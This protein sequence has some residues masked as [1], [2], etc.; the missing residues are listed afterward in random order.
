MGQN[1]FAVVTVLR[2]DPS[3]NLTCV[4]IVAKPQKS[5]QGMRLSLQIY[6]TQ[7]APQNLSLQS[8]KEEVYSSIEIVH[9]VYRSIFDKLVASNKMK[10]EDRDAL[11]ADF[12][13]NDLK[14]FEPAQSQTNGI[15]NT[16]YFIWRSASGEPAA[17]LRA[18]M[19][20]AG[21]QRQLPIEAKGIVV[22]NG[23][24]VELERV[25][26]SPG[27]HAEIVSREMMMVLAQFLEKYFGS[28]DYE[29]YGQTDAGR[30]RLY[31]RDYGFS[32]KELPHESPLMKYL[33]NVP[34]ETLHTRYVGHIEQAFKRAFTPPFD[35][36]GALEYLR[37]F[38]SKRGMENYIPNLV[39]QSAILASQKNYTAALEIVHHLKEIG[40]AEVNLDYGAL[41]ESRTLFDAIKN[42]GDADAALAVIQQHLLTNPLLTTSYNDRALLFL[43]TKLKILLA[44]ERFS[45][46]QNLID[47]NK[48]LLIS[49]MKQQKHLYDLQMGWVAGTFNYPYPMSV[50]R[51]NQISLMWDLSTHMDPYSTSVLYPRTYQ[52]A[53]D[54]SAKLGLKDQAIRFRRIGRFLE[55]Q[56]LIP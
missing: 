26:N 21:E 46:A 51:L 56:R 30:A 9:N 34:G 39:A 45:E 7:M 53:A 48:I 36:D 19:I 15:E 25:F 42:Q 14:R 3:I 31:H 35:P 10:A 8:L 29:A 54:D 22:P 50:A 43:I 13:K 16:V 40:H 32:T 1:A 11:L 18:T 12:K 17:I 38:E 41:W 20:R 55:Q 4:D 6:P 5:M 33:V 24:R 52:I 2:A 28:N 44:K 47:Q 23:N 37:A 49:G 27:S